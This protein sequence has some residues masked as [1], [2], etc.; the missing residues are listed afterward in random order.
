MIDGLNPSKQRAH[1]ACCDAEEGDAYPS[2]A[3]CLAFGPPQDALALLSSLS[4][5]LLRAEAEDEEEEEGG[6]GVGATEEDEAEE[7]AAAASGSGRTTT[8]TGSDITSPRWHAGRRKAGARPSALSPRATASRVFL[9]TP[10][11]DSYLSEL[12]TCLDCLDRIDPLAIGVGCVFDCST[13]CLL[14]HISIHPPARTLIYIHQTNQIDDDITISWAPWLRP[15]PP[16][17]SPPPG[18]TPPRPSC[19]TSFRP[20]QQPQLQLE[21]HAPPPPLPAA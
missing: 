17:S 1:T 20:Q 5:R 14:W 8:S 7:G 11:L 2:L 4:L 12:P 21:R 3:S 19:P 9:S 10:G 6:T 18:P 15:R 16:C 13:A